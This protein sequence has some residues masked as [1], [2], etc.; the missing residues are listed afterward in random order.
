[1]FLTYTY[2][3][4]VCVCVCTSVNPP[5]QVDGVTSNQPAAYSEAPSLPPNSYFLTLF[6][7]LLG[8]IHRFNLAALAI[9]Y[10]LAFIGEFW[11]LQLFDANQP[12]FYRLLLMPFYPLRSSAVRLHAIKRKASQIQPSSAHTQF[13]SGWQNKT[14]SKHLKDTPPPSL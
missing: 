4:C 1:M 2:I 10:S 5:I 14:F 3:F 12:D 7:I 6:S 13:S 8:K 9:I 11:R